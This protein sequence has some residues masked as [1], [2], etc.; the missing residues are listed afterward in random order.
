MAEN[1]VV[2]NRKDGS[3]LCVGAENIYIRVHMPYIHVLAAA[4]V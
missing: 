1:P 3:S 4:I 2:S